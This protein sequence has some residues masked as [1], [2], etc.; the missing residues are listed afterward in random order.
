VYLRSSFSSF[1]A[2]R[3]LRLHLMNDLIHVIWNIILLWAFLYLIYFTGF[4]NRLL[5]SLHLPL[6]WIRYRNRIISLLELS[7]LF[8]KHKLI[9]PIICDNSGIHLL[10]HHCKYILTI[11]MCLDLLCLRFLIV[12]LIIISISFHWQSLIMILFFILLILHLDWRILFDLRLSF[13]LYWCLPFSL[14]L[15]NF[16]RVC[17]EILLLIAF[18]WVFYLYLII[19]DKIFLTYWLTLASTLWNLFIFHGSSTIL[20][21]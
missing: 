17:W 18:G 6:V 4:R 2:F 14:C 21:S 11:F 10:I 19:M 20:S 16:I 15:S 5:C 8:L 13:H 9:I 12:Y 7:I 1:F 3:R